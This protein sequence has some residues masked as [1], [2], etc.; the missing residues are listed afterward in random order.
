MDLEGGDAQGAGGA[1]VLVRGTRATVP[2]ATAH[3]RRPL[4]SQD[5]GDELD[6]VQSDGV[7]MRSLAYANKC[8]LCRA[9]VPQG[10]S[11]YYNKHADSGQRITCKDCHDKRTK[12]ADD[13]DD[14]A[15]PKATH[16]KKRGRKAAP[17]VTDD[18][19]VGPKGLLLLY[20]KAKKAS[21]AL[22]KG[23]AAARLDAGLALLRESP[24]PGHPRTRW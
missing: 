4:P 6:A 24:T 10:S 19:L 3:P 13:A 11:G 2:R 18:C 23:D 1:D 15:E 20:K 16:V 17:K 14:V 9:E 8:R 5:E 12:P 21:A 22:K 7:L